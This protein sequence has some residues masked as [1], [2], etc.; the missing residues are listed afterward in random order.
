MIGQQQVTWQSHNKSRSDAGP[1]HQHRCHEHSIVSLMKN[2]SGLEK[3]E[4]EDIIHNWY[5]TEVYWQIFSILFLPTIE[6]VDFTQVAEMSFDNSEE[7]LSLLWVTT[8][9]SKYNW[10]QRNRRAGP[11][12]RRTPP[13]LRASCCWPWWSRWRRRTR[14]CRGRWRACRS[15]SRCPGRR[16]TTHGGHSAA[17]AVKIVKSDT[18]YF[19]GIKPVNSIQLTK[20]TQLII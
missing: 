18:A 13:A 14:G 4:D 10:R 11:A 7:A 9:S 19:S 2:D 16:R 3:N 20:I 6:Q 12:C 17:P 8:L 1:H 15:A 5:C